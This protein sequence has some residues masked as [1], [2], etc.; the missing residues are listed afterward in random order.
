MSIRLHTM[1]ASH[2]HCTPR[3]GLHSGSLTAK[4]DALYFV[5]KGKSHFSKDLEEQRQCGNIRKDNLE[6]VGPPKR[7]IATARR[8][9]VL[10]LELIQYLSDFW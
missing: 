6:F 5:A 9:N 8:K 7:V 4:T 10:G 1:A 2:T 3:F